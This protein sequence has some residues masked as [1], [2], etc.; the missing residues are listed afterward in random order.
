MLPLEIRTPR[1]LLRPW[2]SHDV[3]DLLGYADDESWSRYIPAPFPY[4]ED[5]AR[6]FLEIQTGL[7]WRRHCGWAMEH[8]GRASGGLDLRIDA[9]TCL[10]Q[11]DYAL[12]RRLWN[13]GLTTEAV[14]TVIDLAFERIPLLTRLES[15]VHV[16]NQASK[17]VLEKV[18]MT[19]VSKPCERSEVGLEI[20]FGLARA[21]WEAPPKHLRR[22]V[23]PRRTSR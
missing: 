15:S 19:R 2:S 4:G 17:R 1:L 18:G 5:D 22:S 10:G 12:A 20:S 9:D 8:E 14:R 23:R 6:Q 13:R 3:A 7:D 11:L 21:T 16:D